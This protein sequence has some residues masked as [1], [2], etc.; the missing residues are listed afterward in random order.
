MP[1]DFALSFRAMR[2]TWVLCALPVLVL[3]ACGPR[4]DFSTHDP[5][6]QVVATPWELDRALAAAIERTIDERGAW[7]ALLTPLD[8]Q[9]RIDHDKFAAHAQE[10]LTHGCTGVTLFGTT[11]EGPSF[12]VAERR[13]AM[14]VARRRREALTRLREKQ[15]AAWKAEFARAEEVM[16]GDMIT[17]RHG[18]GVQEAGA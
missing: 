6:V 16:I 14:L 11:G 15:H 4:D 3:A 7:P 8:A 2:S 5:G 13:E 17:A 9:L 10:R 18:L 12:S 1:I